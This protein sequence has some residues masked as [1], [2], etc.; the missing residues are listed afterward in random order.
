M[1]FEKLFNTKNGRIIGIILAHEVGLTIQSKLYDYPDEFYVDNPNP[2]WNFMDYEYRIK[3]YPT[4]KAWYKAL[5]KA[6]ERR[7]IYDLKHIFDQIDQIV[8]FNIFHSKNYE[9]KIND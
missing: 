4:K 5:R 7:V 1:K 2:Q 3:K 6:S 9:E 8:F